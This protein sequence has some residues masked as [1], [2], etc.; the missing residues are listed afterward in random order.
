MFYNGTVILIIGK[1][2]YSFTHRTRDIVN[3]IA[4]KTSRSS[5]SCLHM[6]VDTTQPNKQFGYMYTGYSVTQ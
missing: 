3:T 5:S 2:T 4:N 6:I 1:K